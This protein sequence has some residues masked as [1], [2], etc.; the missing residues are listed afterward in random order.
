MVFRI[1]LKCVAVGIMMIAAS[2]TLVAQTVKTLNVANGNDFKPFTDNRL[3]KG[4]MA[5]LITEEAFRLSGWEISYQWLPWKR[6]YK[7]TR[8]ME[9]DAAIPW[10]RRADTTQDLA[11]SD[12]LITMLDQVWSVEAEGIGSN[13][14]LKGKT[15]CIPIGYTVPEKQKPMYDVGLFKLVSPATMTACF[16]MLA[17][18]HVDFVFCNSVQG[19]SIL[20]DAALKQSNIQP[21]LSAKEPIELFLVMSKYHPL[22]DEILSDF[23][24][25]LKALRAKGR[26]AEIIANY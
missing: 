12:P 8:S 14:D 9:L 15:G 26:Y 24:K 7:M 11:Y 4:G 1:L 20:K 2:G 13:A 6:G 3:P 17:K 22:Q 23:N 5:S 25:G 21:V 16:K 19:H 18:K 10:T